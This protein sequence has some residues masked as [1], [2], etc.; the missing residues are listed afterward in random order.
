MVASGLF[1]SAA[2]TSSRK[3]QLAFARQQ[4]ATQ[5]DVR[6]SRGRSVAVAELDPDD[7]AR[8]QTPDVVD[9]AARA[10]EVEDVEEDTRVRFAAR[11][12]DRLRELQVREPA[13][14]EE[15]Q[16]DAETERRRPP[17]DGRRPRRPRPEPGA[18]DPCSG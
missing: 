6:G 1:C 10:V 9:R 8:R 5:R 18:T 2:S 7:R 16:A 17:A 14:G 13:V 4:P 15:L 12:D 11:L 3:R